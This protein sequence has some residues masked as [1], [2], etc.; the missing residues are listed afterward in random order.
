[1][2]SYCWELLGVEIRD[3]IRL[4]DAHV[5]RRR[6][7]GEQGFRHQK[8]NEIHGQILGGLQRPEFDHGPHQESGLMI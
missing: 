7:N 1:V 2:L 4:I 8:L 6:E 3:E 5:P